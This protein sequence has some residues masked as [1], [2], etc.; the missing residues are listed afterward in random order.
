MRPTRI[1]PPTRE[2][3]APGDSYRAAIERHLAS[4]ALRILKA[5]HLARLAADREHGRPALG[6]R[7]ALD[8][9]ARADR[10]RNALVARLTRIAWE[11]FGEQV[12][13]P[14]DL[15]SV[16]WRDRLPA[17]TL[18]DR[19][20]RAAWAL[21]VFDPERVERWADGGRRHVPARAIPDHLVAEYA[22]GGF[23]PAQ[24]ARMLGF[25]LST[26][27][28]ALARLRAEGVDLTPR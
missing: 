15:H 28:R 3:I 21:A 7:P 10:I 1:P 20:T 25:G 26:V 2:N 27:Y 23:I 18:D 12:T 24:S 17:E 11:Q 5:A 13:P 8:D 14:G 6:I 4:E 9:P 16:R 22:R 19:T